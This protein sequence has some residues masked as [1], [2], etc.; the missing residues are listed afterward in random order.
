M[1]REVN[2]S[3]LPNGLTV[4]SDRMSNV[5]SISLGLWVR[6]GARYERSSE[7]GV[8]HFLEHMLFKGTERRTSKD[9]V[10]EIES[11]GG[12]INAYTSR[13]M[14]AFFSKVLKGDYCLALDV[15]ADIVQNSVFKSSEI[16]KERAVI[17]QEIGQALDSPDDV[18]FDHF[19]STA[20]PNQPLG[21]PVLGKPKTVS[22]LTDK[23]IRGFLER[24]Y[25]GSSMVIAAAGNIHHQELLE[26]C[27]EY[28]GNIKTGKQTSASSGVF[29]GGEHRE[30]RDLEQIHFIFGFSGPAIGSSDFYAMSVLSNLLGGGMSS[31]LF[32]DIREKRGLVYSIDSFMSSYSDVGLFGIYAGTGDNQ[33]KELIPALC[34]QIRGLADSLSIEEVERARAQ[35][36]SSLLM[37]LESTG[38]RCEQIAQHILIFG[39]VMPIEEVVARL[40]SIDVIQVSSLAKEIFANSPVIAAVG[41]IADLEQI[42]IIAERLAA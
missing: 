7:N 33:I 5:E 20:F 18:I 15:I 24:H 36:K 42:D 8:A 26:R 30:Y 39:R 6:A 1:N 29:S 16:D 19:Q 25:Q 21:R 41:P 4:V 27:E 37:A 12:S 9:I 17:L 10:E 35:I 14:T 11:V 32:Q 13:E 40:D 38:A 31:R 22:D 28:F 23:E 2:I 34:D 3:K